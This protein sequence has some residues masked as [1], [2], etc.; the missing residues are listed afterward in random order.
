MHKEKYG[1]EELNTYEH[2]WQFKNYF[3]DIESEYIK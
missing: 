1:G 2:K 3:N